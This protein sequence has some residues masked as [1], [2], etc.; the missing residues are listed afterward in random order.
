MSALAACK[1]TPPEPQARLVTLTTIDLRS[2]GES[3]GDI[4]GNQGDFVAAQFTSN[5][6]LETNANHDLKNRALKLG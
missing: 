4:T 6:N 5:N 1:V 2:E 3:L